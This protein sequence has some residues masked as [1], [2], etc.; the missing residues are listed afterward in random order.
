MAIPGAH[1][2]NLALTEKIHLQPRVLKSNVKV[3]RHDGCDNEWFLSG[4]TTVSSRMEL[5]SVFV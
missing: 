3:S 2:V 4:A 1:A 5:A